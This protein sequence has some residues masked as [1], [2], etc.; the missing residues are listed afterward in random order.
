MHISAETW[1]AAAA[2][3]SAFAA[4]LLLRI[5]LRSLR[6]AAQ[7][8]LVITGW[9]R[10][11]STNN[12]KTKD[13]ITFSTI[14]NVGR[15]PALHVNIGG[16]FL[17]ADD[18]RLKVSMPNIYESIIAPNGRI[19][20][21]GDISIRWKNVAGRPGS[22][23]APFN[24]NIYCWDSTGV[25]YL[26]TY[27]LYAAEPFGQ[28]IVADQIAPGVMLGTRSV[29]AEPVWWLKLRSKLSTILFIG[30]IFKDKGNFPVVR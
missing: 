22:K 25:R 4:F 7:P 20:V 26:T 24:I 27:N 12:L 18:E 11:S 15:G 14:E 23:F 2:I 19:P 8:E 10:T 9:N 13:N 28:G 5:E 17:L 30:R 3:C 1:S 6:Y 21:D 16:I 29:I